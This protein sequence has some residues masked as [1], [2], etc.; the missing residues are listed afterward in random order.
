MPPE[1]RLPL[2]RPQRSTSVWRHDRDAHMTTWPI[3]QIA[4]TVF[5]RRA[6][7]FTIWTPPFNLDQR[8]PAKELF[9]RIDNNGFHHF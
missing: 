2:A 3:N 6:Y 7:Q 1:P 5:N 4:H 8:P 9:C